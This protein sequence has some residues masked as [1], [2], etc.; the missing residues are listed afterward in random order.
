MHFFIRVMSLSFPF[1]VC[2]VACRT[3]LREEGF[4]SDAEL[5]EPLTRANFGLLG[6]HFFESSK[7]AKRWDIQ[8]EF[9][10]LHRTENYLFLKQ[11][12]ADF[13]AER[14]GNVVRTT[15]EHGRS[16]LDKNE[17]IL[18]GNVR[19]LSRSGYEFLLNTLNYDGDRH[20]FSSPDNVSM[21]GPGVTRPTMVVRGTGLLADIDRE[22]FFLG[23]RVT[24][25]KRVKSDAWMHIRSS[26]GEFFTQ[27]QKAV[28]TGRVESK[29]PPGLII[30]SDLMQMVSRSDHELMEARGNVSLVFKDK[31]GQAE[32]AFFEA[33]GDRVILEGNA[34]VESKKSEVSGK[35]IVLYTMD[36]RVEVTQAQGRI[37]D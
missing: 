35:R 18:D 15:S 23:K 25:R 12:T 9:A 19:I 1:L 37:R 7:N 3:S 8:S 32:Q 10:E 24:A 2:L 4:S 27:E 13:H 22:H 6:V 34:R 36:D 11:V 21:Q 17:V 28:F 26:Q 14:T 30:R 16:F 5:N 31:T 33:G 29:V 20:E